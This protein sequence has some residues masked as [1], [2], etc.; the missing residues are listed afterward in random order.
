MS[1]FV[2]AVY[3]ALV[4][5]AIVVEIYAQ[6]KPNQIAPL[7]VTLSKAANSRINRVGLT[8]AWWWF[9]WHFLFAQT[10]QTNL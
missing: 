6:L 5:A 2:T 4:A 1:A 10:I 9:G 8:A 7:G 3:L